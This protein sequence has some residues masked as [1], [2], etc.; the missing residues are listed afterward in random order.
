[1]LSKNGKSTNEQE[2][3]ELLESYL[4]FRLSRQA[5]L[6]TI[7]TMKFYSK[8]LGVFIEWLINNGIYKPEDIS[9]RHVREFLAYH[10]GRGCSDSYIHTFARSIRTYLR[11]LHK[12]GYIPGDISFQMPRIGYKKLH[13]LSLEEVKAVLSACENLRDKAIILML[14]DTGLRRSEICALNW[15]DVDIANGL[16]HVRQ[17]KG[18]K[19]RSV[20]I[21]FLTRRTLLKYGRTVSMDANAPLFQSFRGDRLSPGGLRSMCVRITKRTG[22]Y[23][24]PHAFRRT[25]VV[26][27][28]TNGMSLAHVQAFMGH[29]TPTMTLEYAKLVDDDLLTAHQKHGPVDGLLGK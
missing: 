26:L 15:D 2:P 12:E 29:A 21:G 24:T 4:D 13:V 22:I 1:M 14:V 23:I 7:Q 25:F 20:V 8:T 28:L 10:Q 19:A 16:C 5:M 27:S 3:H 17:G 18:K 6:C 9:S 11:F